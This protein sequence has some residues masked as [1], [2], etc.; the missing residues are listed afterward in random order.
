METI[1]NIYL[2]VFTGFYESIH[3]WRID[4]VEEYYIE[5]RI[6]QGATA[7][8]YDKMTEEFDIDYKKIHNEYAKFFATEFIDQY[9]KEIEEETWIKINKFVALNSPKFYNYW[10]DEIEVEVEAIDL[11]KTSRFILNNKFRDYIAKEN[12]IRDG[13]V[14][15]MPDQVLKYNEIL[16]DEAPENMLTQIITF[17]LIDNYSDLDNIDMEIGDTVDTFDLLLENMKRIWK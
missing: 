4:S 16:R 11:W 7:Y 9:A 3:S 12:A 6:K 15:F 17:Y 13:F 2:P 10:T 1:K 5:D 14:P 8:D